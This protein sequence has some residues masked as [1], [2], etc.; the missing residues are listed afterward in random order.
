LLWAEKGLGHSM[1]GMEGCEVGRR[2]R[3]MLGLLAAE[4][5]ELA[6]VLP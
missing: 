4:L 3:R 2:A 1:A 5:K 6:L